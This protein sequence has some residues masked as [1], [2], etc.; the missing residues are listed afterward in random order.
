MGY[1]RLVDSFHCLPGYNLRRQIKCMII[2]HFFYIQEVN[3]RSYR[4]T[5]RNQ[6]ELPWPAAIINVEEFE[7]TI[8]SSPKKMSSPT[9][10]NLASSNRT[11]Q[12]TE[13]ILNYL[14][15]IIWE[16]QRSRYMQCT[17]H[18][19]PT[20]LCTSSKNVEP[21]AVSAR[22]KDS[23]NAVRKNENGQTRCFFSKPVFEVQRLPEML[24]TRWKLRRR[25]RVVGTVK[26]DVEK[27]QILWVLV[28]PDG[29][30]KSWQNIG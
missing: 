16:Y 26:V 23:L 2:D 29:T 11:D 1:S 18:F 27:D 22:T 8:V 15:E 21:P 10:S 12:M 20:S 14:V 24:S 4:R 13:A 3:E 6:N 5:Q 9:S 7:Y 17:M 25:K 28:I 19:Q 30:P